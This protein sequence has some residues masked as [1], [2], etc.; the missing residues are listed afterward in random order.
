[1]TSAVSDF[2]IDENDSRRIILATDYGVIESENA[3]ENWR[4]I[5]GW[6]MPPVLTVRLRGKEIWAATARGVFVSSDRGAQ[7]V[8]RS[9]GLPAPD[10][11]YVSDLLFTTDALLAAT[12]D[13]IFRS[14]DDGKSWFRSGLNGE[15]IFRI[16]VHPKNPDLFA[17]VREGKS[18]YVSSDGGR[19]WTDKS[20][21]LPTRKVKCAAFD[22]G[23]Q[24]TILVGTV[25]MGVIRSIDLG[26]KWEF[27]SGGLTNFN[28]TVLL[29]DSG[30][31]DRVYAGAENGSF[32][33]NNRGKTWQAFSIRLGYVSAMEMR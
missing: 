20:A 17:A 23:D 24:N 26:N 15:E 28:I 31:P 33:S 32:L 14:T 3:G 7:W 4:V 27:S 13:G 16:M 25:D 12:A 2:A 30:L 9:V 29:F 19:I 8:S 11:S 1:V 22:P 21:N 18:I 6:N 10:G 5:S